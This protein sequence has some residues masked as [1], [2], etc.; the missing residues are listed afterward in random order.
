MIKAQIMMTSNGV[1]WSYTPSEIAALK[2]YWNEWYANQP[3]GD[4]R[5]RALAPYAIK[6]RGFR[7]IDGSSRNRKTSKEERPDE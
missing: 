3:E 6:K 7:V 4:S 5:T 1:R 2:A